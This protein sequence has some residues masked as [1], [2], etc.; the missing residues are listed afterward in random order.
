MFECKILNKYVEELYFLRVF[1]FLSKR[2][3]TREIRRRGDILLY[4][5]V[6]I[7]L[8]SFAKV[9]HLYFVTLGDIKHKI[10]KMRELLH[11]IKIPVVIS[12][13]I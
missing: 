2:V 6:Y 4:P 10:K 13:K 9:Q 7:Y 12:R 1:N 5:I 11:L 8:Y 3:Y